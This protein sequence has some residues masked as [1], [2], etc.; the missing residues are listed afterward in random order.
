MKKTIVLLLG[1]GLAVLV[2]LTAY[3]LLIPHERPS[4]AP[5]STRRPAGPSEMAN[6]PWPQAATDS[7]CRG[8][9]HWIDSSSSDGTVVELFDFDFRANPSLRLELFDQDEDDAKPFDNSA[10]FWTRGVAQVAGKLNDTGRGKIIAAWNGL[11]FSP[12][13]N[14]PG[15]H[16]APVVLAGKAYYNVGVVRWAVGVKHDRNGPVF[17]AIR[18]P[19]FMTLGSEF[20]YGAEGAPTGESMMFFYVR[21]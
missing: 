6:W 15:N 19:D 4:S 9:K 16:V 20:D 11:F 18:L 1:L 5:G 21:E 17:K 7:P 2:A 10:D 14:S 3:P 13:P 12:P 8:V